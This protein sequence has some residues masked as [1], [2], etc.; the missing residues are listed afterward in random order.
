MKKENIYKFLYAVCI[1]LIVG[2]VIRNWYLNEKAPEEQVEAILKRKKKV[3]SMDANNVMYD[4]Y[5]LI[6]ETNGESKKFKVHKSIYKQY[7]ENEKG[8]LVFKRN[9]FMSFTKR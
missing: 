1:F 8:I 2:F 5:Y 7:N 4:D 6:F 3:S 9:R